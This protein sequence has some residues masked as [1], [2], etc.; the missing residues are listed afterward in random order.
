MPH[1]FDPLLGLSLI[2]A[3]GYLGGKIAHRLRL[4]SIIG[5]IL[6]GA[7]LG[8]HGLGVLPLSLIVKDLRLVSSIAFGFIAVSVA[9]H[10]RV[11]DLRATSGAP[12]IIALWETLLAFLLVAGAIYLGTGSERLSLLA[13][14]MAST[15]APAASLAVVRESRARGPFVSALLPTIALD[16]IIAILLFTSVMA[17]LRVK[18]SGTFLSQIAVPIVVGVLVGSAFCFL[19]ASLKRDSRKVLGSSFLGLM[20]ASG[21]AEHLNTSPFLATITL[22]FVIANCEGVHQ[23]V[24]KALRELEPLIYL[25]FFTMAGVHLRFDVIVSAGGLIFVFVLGRFVGK[26][27]GGFLGSLTSPLS[28]S[29]RGLLGLGLLPQAGLALGFLVMVQEAPGLGDVSDLLSAMVLSAV[30]INEFVGPLAIRF[31]L[32]W[33]KEEGKALPPVLGFLEEEDIYLDLD[34][35]DKWEAISRLVKFLCNR[36]CADLDLEG[37]FLEEVVKRELSMTTGIGHGLAIPHGVIEYQGGVI[38]VLGISQRG[39][40][41]GSL[42]GRPAHVI[43]L[44]LVPEE[45]L[46]EHLNALREFSR[47]FSK[48]F[49]MPALMEAR[50]REEVMEV[51]REAS[52]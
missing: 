36:R 14:A 40:E 15:T 45:R 33:A 17:F 42:D 6:A 52:L 30:I 20:A 35:Q 19:P 2:I 10:L 32:R 50:T 16:N 5:N 8:P 23:E 44:T 21:I 12:L 49:V 7:M 38:G 22:G 43:L 25:I 1:I 11:R 37:R 3:F 51:L 18:G 28:S 46:Q 4:P 27:L 13:G 47:I 34:A 29:W 9:L 41:F 31:A 26:F 48:P 39:I 24:S